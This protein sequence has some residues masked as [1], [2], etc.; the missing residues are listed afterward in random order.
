M[1]S[2]QGPFTIAVVYGVPSAKR[3]LSGELKSN[4]RIT[5]RIAKKLKR[6]ERN[7]VCHSP[8]AES[9]DAQVMVSTGARQ[10]RVQP[11]RGPEES[12]SPDSGVH[13]E[14]AERGLP[15]ELPS[16]EQKSTLVAYVLWLFLGG[17]GLHHLY[18]RRTAHGT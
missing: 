9:R 18:L 10:R 8:G 14:E 11:T 17:F 7:G 12:L 2:K 5:H 1:F 15:A 13:G 6:D 3:P 4:K 16:R